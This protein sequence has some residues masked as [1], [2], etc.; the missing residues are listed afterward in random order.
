MGNLIG[1]G[2]VQGA[3]QH[4]SFIMSLCF[5]LFSV[6]TVCFWIVKDQVLNLYTD[7]PEVRELATPILPLLVVG[8]FFE[9]MRGGL[10]KGFLKAYNIYMQQ[11][12]YTLVG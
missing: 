5:I 2:D 4:K 8:S 6:I 3:A 12:K 9:L 7:I 11:L 10:F 1:R